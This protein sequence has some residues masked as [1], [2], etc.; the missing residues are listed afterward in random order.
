MSLKELFNGVN[1]DSE[2]YRFITDFFSDTNLEQKTILEHTMLFSCLHVFSSYCSRFVNTSLIELLQR[3]YFLLQISRGGRGRI[4]AVEMT[5]NTGGMT[6][7]MS[8]Q[9]K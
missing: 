7:D 2:M 6:N 5:K 1:E 8:E 3:R 9:A 4:D